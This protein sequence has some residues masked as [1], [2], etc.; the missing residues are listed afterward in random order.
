MHF[1]GKV[2][3]TDV[4]LFSMNLA[5]E[6]CRRAAHD[7]RDTQEQV[8]IAS[9]KTVAAIVRLAASDQRIVVMPREWDA[10]RWCST[11]QAAS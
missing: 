11:P 10:D 1:D 4:R 9:A 8:R 2:W 3:L 7:A 6:F 5:R